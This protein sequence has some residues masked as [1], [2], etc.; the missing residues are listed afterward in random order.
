MPEIRFPREFD[1]SI[2]ISTE[3]T[4]AQSGVSP[5]IHYCKTLEL[6]E[7]YPVHT[8]PRSALQ[9]TDKT[10]YKVR[11]V[12]VK[13]VYIDM[14]G[15]PGR[16][17]NTENEEY[18]SR[19]YQCLYSGEVSTI[20]GSVSE[21]N[22]T[23]EEKDRLEA[24][25]KYLNFAESVDELT[26]DQEQPDEKAS[27]PVYIL[28]VTLSTSNFKVEKFAKKSIKKAVITFDNGL[29]AKLKY[30]ASGK[31]DFTTESDGT[32]IIITGT[33]NYNGKVTTSS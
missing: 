30:N 27:F 32:I 24:L 9:N 11:D 25:D 1:K 3:E 22:L 12:C 6:S 21:N 20:W 14:A 8:A 2:K 18:T 7:K 13:N 31:K 33:N 28:P 29:S 17:F 23:P 15:E 19:V 5:I 16:D 4:S 10:E 26:P